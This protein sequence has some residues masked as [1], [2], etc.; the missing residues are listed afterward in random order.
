MLLIDPVPKFDKA[1]SVS[2]GQEGRIEEPEDDG[3]FRI[4]ASVNQDKQARAGKKRLED[5]R[6]ERRTDRKSASPR[7]KLPIADLE[8]KYHCPPKV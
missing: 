3:A 6:G 4:L 1:L 8:L 7:Q 5:P 2:R